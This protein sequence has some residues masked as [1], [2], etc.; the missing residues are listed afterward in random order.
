MI[1]LTLSLRG[2]KQEPPKTIQYMTKVLSANLLG[3]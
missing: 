2:Q 1:C 3:A